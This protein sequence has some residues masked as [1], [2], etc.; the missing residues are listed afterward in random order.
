MNI[1]K[2]KLIYCNAPIA[3]HREYTFCL[4]QETEA[5][6]VSKTNPIFHDLA[7]WVYQLIEANGEGKKLGVG[8]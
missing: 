1:F 3:I 6:H 7:L 8:L 4:E 2:K 5:K